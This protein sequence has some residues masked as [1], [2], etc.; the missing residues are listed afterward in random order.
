MGMVGM[1]GVALWLAGWVL[2]VRA[3]EAMKIGVMDQQAVMERSRAGK[4][5]LEEVKNYSAT[6]QKIINSDEE[7][8]RDLEQALQDPNS[9]LSESA[10][11]EKQEQLRNKLEAYQRRVQDF[12]REIQQKQRD[13]VAEYSKKIAD[14][15]QAVAQKEGYMAILDKGNDA[16][17]RIVI[18]YQPSLDV[19]ELVLKEF[20]RQNN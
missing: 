9:K 17:L 8:M 4:L 5:A 18:Y 19:T 6:R 3:G 11:Q 15:A 10:K 14:A 12:N 1:L 16:L 2:P 13:L 7:E 20:D